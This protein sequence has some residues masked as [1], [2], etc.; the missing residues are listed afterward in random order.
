MIVDR[1]RSHS[2]CGGWV[3]SVYSHPIPSHR[4]YTQIEGLLNPQHSFGWLKRSISR[5]SEK[6]TP[7]ICIFITN[8]GGTTCQA[9]VFFSSSSSSSRRR[10]L[11][12]DTTK[13][14]R[15]RE[16]IRSA[17]PRPRYH[18]LNHHVVESWMKRRMTDV[19]CIRQINEL[20]E[21]DKTTIN[22]KT[23]RI[24][25]YLVCAL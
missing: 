3:D 14:H 18:F 24:I 12:A 1:F 4:H 19:C 2:V 6:G 22:R 5:W 15:E 11:S 23:K 16:A 9:S 8:G 20:F 17:P 21:Y 13:I 10:A 25:S 7:H